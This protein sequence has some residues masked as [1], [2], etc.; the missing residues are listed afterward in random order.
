MSFLLLLT[1]IFQVACTSNQTSK[2]DAKQEKSTSTADSVQEES[3]CLFTDAM[4]CEVELPVNPERIVTHY[5]AAEMIAINQAIIG[6]N[7]K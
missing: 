5:Y 3:V 4:G 2:D 1:A 7:S 6:T